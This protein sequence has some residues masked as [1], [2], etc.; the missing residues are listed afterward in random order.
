MTQDLLVH[1]G[2]PSNVQVSRIEQDLAKDDKPVY[3]YDVL[4]ALQALYPDHRIVFGLGPDNVEQFSRFYRHQDILDQ[5]EL[6]ECPTI[7]T[8]RLTHTRHAAQEDNRAFIEQ[9]TA[10]SL[11]ERVLQLYK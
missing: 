6:E 5:L 1:F 11:T 10:P 8:V 3:T 4:V 2:L 9:Y 7:S